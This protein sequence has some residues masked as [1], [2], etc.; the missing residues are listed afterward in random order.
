VLSI[1]VIG[2]V[3]LVVNG[4]AIHR[5]SARGY[6]RIGLLLGLILAVLVLGLMG[7]AFFCM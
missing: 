3:S 6:A 4:I 1:V 5:R 7:L 2:P